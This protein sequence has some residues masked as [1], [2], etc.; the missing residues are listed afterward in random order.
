MS[1]SEPTT[2]DREPIRPVDSIRLGT[3]QAA[4]WQDETEHGPRFGVTLE[5]LYREKDGNKWQ[6]SRTFRPG[7]LPT[8]I[9]V[10]TL[11]VVD[12]YHRRGDP[13]DEGI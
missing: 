1:E 3:I 7:D 8:L 6:S 5:R 4:I 9:Q 2:R 10:L 12:L 11:V 13:W